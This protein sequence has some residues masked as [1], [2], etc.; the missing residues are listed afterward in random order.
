MLCKN[1]SNAIIL[2]IKILIYKCEI[3]I[4]IKFR[5]RLRDPH[6]AARKGTYILLKFHYDIE[7][8]A[9]S[10]SDHDK[11]IRKWKLVKKINLMRW[12]ESVLLHQAKLIQRKLTIVLF[13]DRAR[14]SFFEN[15]Q[16]HSLIALGY[17]STLMSLLKKTYLLNSIF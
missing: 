9:C 14:S 17:V 7:K 16:T 2:L 10:F 12:K 3:G 11:V 5:A 15:H 1:S 6:F 13:L 4:R 8:Y